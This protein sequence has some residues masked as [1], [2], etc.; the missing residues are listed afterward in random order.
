MADNSTS[1]DFE[2][3]LSSVRRLVTHRTDI[4]A[5]PPPA[6]K[7]LLTP[8]LRVSGNSKISEK[9]DREAATTARSALE[10]RIA[11]LEA[12]VGAQS[13]DWEPDGSEDLEAEIPD[14]YVFAHTPADGPLE[15]MPSFD[16]AAEV[17]VVKG[18]PEGADVAEEAVSEAAGAELPVPAPDSR[19]TVEDDHQA[20]DSVLERHSADDTVLNTPDED[21][22]AAAPEDEGEDDGIAAFFQSERRRLEGESHGSEEEPDDPDA[23]TDH[24]QFSVDLPAEGEPDVSGD[25][26]PLEETVAAV[27]ASEIISLLERGGRDDESHGP[28]NTG[29]APAG[30]EPEENTSVKGA[31]VAAADP[32]ELHGI[33]AQIVREELQGELGERITRNVRKLVRREI[34]RAIMTRDFE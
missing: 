20:V 21:E 15:P 26:E 14:R 31:V 25:D 11:E 29:K 30:V 2:D 33:V 1:A 28:A 23:S 7:L 17:G 3:V 10:E 12:A 6:E 24:P 4:P 16:E 18:D 32:V 8:S 22:F 5:S 9:P 19:E 34:H 13:F 27:A